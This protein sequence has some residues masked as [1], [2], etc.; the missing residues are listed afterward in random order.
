MMAGMHLEVF[1]WFACRH[2][3]LM[4]SCDILSFKK[5]MV[6]WLDM[7]QAVAVS[8][9]ITYNEQA[10]LTG[11]PCACLPSGALHYIGTELPRHPKQR[12]DADALPLA[13]AD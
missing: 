4:L 6:M 8:A 13:A 1:K 10:V 2:V 9:C 7:M 3:V 11:S 12:G 5:Q